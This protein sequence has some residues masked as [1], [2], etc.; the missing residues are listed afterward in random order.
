MKRE[1][2]TLIELLIVI[3]VIA[4]LTALLVPVLRKSR[5]QTQTIVCGLN[6]KQLGYSLTMYH[7]DNGTFPHAF[8]RTHRN[9]PPGGYAG[10]SVQDPLGWWWFNYITGYSPRYF[11]KESPIW[12]PSREIT[13]RNLKRNVLCGNYGVNKSVCKSTQDKNI[14][15]E[16]TGAP[17]SMNDIKRQSETLLVFDSGY[18]M[19]NWW[20]AT[21]NPPEP[22][23]NSIEDAAYIPGLNIN[24]EK[25]I[26]PGM[27]WDAIKGRHLNKT[28]NVGFADGHVDRTDAEDLY[29]EQTQSGYKN[30]YPLWQP[31]KACD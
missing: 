6:L 14:E 18:S 15:G 16:F 21:N 7:D 28:I 9:P 13:D 25:E 19:I 26:W 8:D 11:Q 17:L 23:G 30:L 24:K 1:G 20:H 3:V 10:N 22:L 5:M 29:I 2:F 4:L 31:N 12:C 27:E